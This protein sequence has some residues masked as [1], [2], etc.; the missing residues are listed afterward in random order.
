MK[1][2]VRYTNHIHWYEIDYNEISIFCTKAEIELMKKGYTTYASISE[3]TIT[4]DNNPP[5]ANIVNIDYGIFTE[6]ITY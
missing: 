6:T 5:K 4:V 3:Y 2:W 1:Y